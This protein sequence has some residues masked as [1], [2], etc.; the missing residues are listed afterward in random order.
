MKLCYTSI[1]LTHSG[2]ATYQALLASEK[3]NDIPSPNIQLCEGLVAVY[4]SLLLHALS[5]NNA[6]DLFRLVGH[7]LNSKTWA[8]VFGGGA[9]VVAPNKLLGIKTFFFF[10]PTS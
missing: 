9:K 10:N 5:N 3:D 6:N 8:S 1:P 7:D 4:M 2:V